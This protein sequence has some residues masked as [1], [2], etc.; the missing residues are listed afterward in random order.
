MDNELN[1]SD[2]NINEQPPAAEPAQEQAEAAEVCAP[3]A[4]APAGDDAAS[5]PTQERRTYWVAIGRL[6]RRH[7]FNA[8]EDMDR[9]SGRQVIVETEYGLDLGLLRERCKGAQEDVAGSIVKMADCGDCQHAAANSSADAECRR[10]FEEAVAAENLDMKLAGIDHSYEQTRITFYYH[11]PGRVDFR[12]LVKTLA[13]RLRRRI[14][15]YQLNLRDQFLFHACIGPC[16]LELC[17]KA[18]PELF[19]EKIPTRL[20]KVQKLSYSPGKMSG[21]CGK[22]YCCLKY[23]VESY[24]EFADFLGVKPGAPFRRKSGDRGE[25][26]VLDWDMLTNQV[27]VDPGDD[28]KEMIFT[29]EEFKRE[30]EPLRQSGQGKRQ[31]DDDDEE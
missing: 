16:G 2:N 5:A 13:S 19:P 1:N 22:P 7:I 24:Q 12:Q 23:E 14:E 21:M 3:D 30:F 25:Y 17:C 4:A 28:E 31:R 11:A 6:Q 26:R 27:F 29:L 8:A 18:K 10:V 9:C 20:A 15:L